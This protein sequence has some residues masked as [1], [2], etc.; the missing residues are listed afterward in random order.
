MEHNDSSVQYQ[1][2]IKREEIEE[3]EIILRS[4]FKGCRKLKDPQEQEHI[5]KVRVV[6]KRMLDNNESLDSQIAERVEHNMK[7]NDDTIFDG[8]SIF[9]D[10]NTYKKVHGAKDKFNAK[11]LLSTPIEE[12]PVSDEEEED[13][14]VPAQVKDVESGSSVSE[15]SIGKAK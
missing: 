15:Q 10:V 7:Y 14:K 8:L 1:T 5:D 9:Q 2:E 3:P 12:I 11:S 13:K 6:F 4:C